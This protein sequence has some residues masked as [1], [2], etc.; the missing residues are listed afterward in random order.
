MSKALVEVARM[1]EGLPE[2]RIASLVLALKQS[3]AVAG[4]DAC[5]RR[6][7]TEG[8]RGACIMLVDPATSMIFYVSD[9]QLEDAG[10]VPAPPKPSPAEAARAELEGKIMALATRF[11]DRASVLLEARQDEPA[12]KLTLVAAQVLEALPSY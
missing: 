10:Y 9:L 11:A 1:L 8:R 3:R 12:S 2:E 6:L 4:D 5:A 7:E